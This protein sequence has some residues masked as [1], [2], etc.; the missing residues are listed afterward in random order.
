MSGELLH[1]GAQ[2][3]C[4]HQ[5][6]LSISSTNV[7]VKVGGQAVALANDT[8]TIAGCNFT[9]PPNKPQFCTTIQWTVTSLRVKVGQQAVVLKT[10]TGLCLSADQ[11]PAGPPQISTTQTRVKGT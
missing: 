7:R 9:I 4:P 10:S 8:Y 1:V 5:G 3:A 6:K 11:I 2:G